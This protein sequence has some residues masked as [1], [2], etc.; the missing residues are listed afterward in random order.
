MT[1]ANHRP[2]AAMAARKRIALVAHD[3]KKDDL[4]EWT[5]FNLDLLRHHKFYATGTTGAILVDRL[6]LEVTRMQSGPLG[7]DQQ[8]GAHI[9]DG[10]IDILIFFWDPLE[11]QPHDPDIRAL[12]RIAA[13]WNIPVATNRATADFLI[14]SPHMTE[15]YERLLTDY[16]DYQHRLDKAGD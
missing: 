15:E 6:G 14:S 1:N 4:L 11:A 13:V 10:D 3:N 9:V 16:Y 5:S 12:L 8:L 2:R 7:G